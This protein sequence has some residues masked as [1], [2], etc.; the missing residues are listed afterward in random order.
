MRHNFW[1]NEVWKDYTPL[2]SD[3]RVILYM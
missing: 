1:T 3:Y 2:I